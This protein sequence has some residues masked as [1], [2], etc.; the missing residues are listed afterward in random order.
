MLQLSTETLNIEGITIYRDHAIDNQFW[1]HE[2]PVVL[3]KRNG[4]PQFTLISYRPSVADDD[5]KG[6]G[7]LMLESEIK[8]DQRLKQKIKA[9]LAGITDKEPRLA[10]IPYDDGNVQIMALDLQGSNGT[11]QDNLEP[12]SFVAV[13][14]I[15]GTSK[16]SLSDSNNAVFGLQLS[17]EG[18]QLMEATFKAGAT[19]VGILYSLTYTAMQPAI[20]ARIEANYKR[21]YDHF[22]MGIDLSAGAPIGGVP[23]YLEAGLDFAFEK[24]VEQKIIKVEIINFSTEN[25]KAE[26]EKMILDFFKDTIIKDWFQPTLQPIPPDKPNP[27]PVPWKPGQPPGGGSPTPPGGGSPTPPGGG[28]PTPPGGGSRTLPGGDT[29]VT[30]SISNDTESEIQKSQDKALE[31][32]LY[33]STA[34]SRDKLQIADDVVPDAPIGVKLA[35]SLRKVKLQEDKIAILEYDRA[36]AVQRVYGAV[37]LIGILGEDLDDAHFLKVDLDGTFFRSIDIIAQ[38][39][40]NIFESLGLS[41]VDVSIDYGNDDDEDHIKH[42]DF[43]FQ[44]NGEN[45]GKVSFFLNRALDL[46]YSLTTQYHFDPLS[47]WEG[48]KISYEIPKRLTMDRTLMVNPF[49]DLGFMKINITAADIDEV[50]MDSTD[51]HIVYDDGEWRTEKVFKVQA[52][53]EEQIWKL[54]LSKPDIREFSYH[55][56][57]HL[58][59]GDT[60]VTESKQQ[61][62]SLIPVNDPFDD[63]LVVEFFPNYNND[64]IQNVFID[65]VYEDEANNYSRKERVTFNSDDQNSKTIRFARMDT[66]LEEFSYK[67]TILGTDN[68]VRRIPEVTTDESLVFLGSVVDQV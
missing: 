50:M 14:K 61:I 15:F 7:F 28:V 9:K 19:P 52:N 67:L 56:V 54:R 10:P 16:S 58:A 18:A 8:M 30:L 26:K 43:R 11:E 64:S 32:K 20:S 33:V 60:V 39:P 53:S 1:Y 38:A 66:S 48:E 34:I 47:G 57:H 36:D 68:S 31:R 2:E 62:A 3:A 42:K 45:E 29:S 65:I 22:S 46:H 44:A 23:V 51:V 12:G 5:V 25:D 37:G 59:N 21:M 13:E 24:L 63:P 49:N 6:G 41:A 17:Q 55:F 27:N 40:E 35:F 4:K